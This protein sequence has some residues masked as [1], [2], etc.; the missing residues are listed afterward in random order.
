MLT[1]SLPFTLQR[2]SDTGTLNQLKTAYAELQLRNPSQAHMNA[3]SLF[4]DDIG[5][6]LY[7]TTAWPTD[8]FVL[9]EVERLVD[10]H[11]E[12][13]FMPT[14]REFCHRLW[15][16]IGTAQGSTKIALYKTYAEA[17]GWTAEMELARMARLNAGGSTNTTNV[18]VV[19]QAPTAADW[20][21]QMLKQQTTVQAEGKRIYE[22][23]E[24]NT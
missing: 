24:Q 12:D 1:E 21:D 7:A 14:R 22:Q 8:P 16:D 18:M 3:R 9:A 17:R 19:M 2:A 11:G 13:F 4:G 15:Q 10:V 5:S 20:E 23:S 6:V